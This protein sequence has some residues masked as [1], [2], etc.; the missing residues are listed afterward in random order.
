MLLPPF[1]LSCSYSRLSPWASSR[2]DSFPLPS[3]SCDQKALVTP[4][5]AQDAQTKP[6]E[7]W[8]MYFLWSILSKLVWMDGHSP[9]QD[10]VE[11]F[12][13]PDIE[14]QHAASVTPVG[15][16]LLPIPVEARGTLPW[17]ACFSRVGHGK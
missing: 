13:S 15:L 17:R 14:L 8:W 3:E 6:R 2:C 12:P 9:P 10:Y 5:R 4:T 1:Y 11:N 7:R 16:S